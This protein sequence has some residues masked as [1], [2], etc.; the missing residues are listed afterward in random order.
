MEHAI[1]KTITLKLHEDPALYESVRDR[2]E[3]IIREREEQ[4]IDD[5]EEFRLLL[6]IRDEMRSHGHVS[7]KDLGIRDAAAPFFGI[8]RN[9]IGANSENAASDQ[10]IA[11]IA[12]TVLTLLEREAVIDWRQKEDVQREMRRQ[13]KRE[14]R[15]R[16]VSSELLESIV[17]SIVDLARV[18][19]P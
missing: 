2:L 15:L 1:A 14:L 7:V 17:T 8:I 4:R 16:G 9:S 6:G 3:R 12:E 11:E 5:A 13:V 10:S 19:L 18:R